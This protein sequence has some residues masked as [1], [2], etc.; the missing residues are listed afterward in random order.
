[1]ATTNLLQ[2]N[3]TAANQENDAAYLADSQR[4]GGAT[5][6]AIFEA[7]LANKAYFQWSTFLTALFTAFANKGFTTSDSNLPTLTAQCANFLTTADL[8]PAVVNV[9][10]AATVTLNAATA[11]GFYLQTLTGNLTIAAVTGASA[12]QL[13]AL[14]YQQDSVGGRTVTFP[15]DFVGAVQPDPAA[16]AVSV[17]VFDWDANTSRMRAQGPLVSANGAF[18]P[19][20]LVALGLVTAGTFTLIG[21]I[22]AGSALLYNGT[23]FVAKQLTAT[24]PSRAFNTVYQNT[25]G[26]EITVYATGSEGPGGAGTIAAYMGPTSGGL[27]AVAQQGITAKNL[28]SSISGSL[29]FRVPANWWYQVQADTPAQAGWVELVYV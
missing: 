14:Y 13:I 6:P 11:N 5:N 4:A 10:Y 2:W 21:S 19:S 3:P 23:S 29:S 25:T 17:Q 24:Y 15:S 26:Y 16:N 7:Q 18:F 27:L 9:P 20:A 1:M 22:S 8:L 12:G 28:S